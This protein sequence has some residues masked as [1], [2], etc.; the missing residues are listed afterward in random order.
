MNLYTAFSCFVYRMLHMKQ[1]HA[2]VALLSGERTA[3]IVADKK[4]FQRP[5]PRKRI[6]PMVTR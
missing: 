3:P 5:E 4:L 1:P 6:V 2:L